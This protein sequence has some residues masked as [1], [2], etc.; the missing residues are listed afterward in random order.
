[1]ILA[2]LLLI[3]LLLITIPFMQLDFLLSFQSIILILMNSFMSIESPNILEEGLTCSTAFITNFVNNFSHLFML[4]SWI[5]SCSQTTLLIWRFENSCSLLTLVE[6]YWNGLDYSFLR[7]LRQFQTR[8]SVQNVRSIYDMLVYYCSGLLL[9]DVNSL[10]E[11][12]LMA[13]PSDILRLY[14]LNSPLKNWF[15]IQF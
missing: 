13:L 11:T 6:F 9:I 10:L 7:L 4:K 8:F 1:M 15:S 3:M 14:V 2:I 5:K 12:C